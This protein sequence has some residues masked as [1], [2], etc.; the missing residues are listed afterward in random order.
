MEEKIRKMKLQN[1]DERN[2][3]RTTRL[4]PNQHQ[5]LDRIQK[6]KKAE[7]KRAKK[8]NYKKKPMITMPEG[9]KLTESQDA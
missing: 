3:K 6:V 2:G 5:K 4:K 8:R 9:E 7:C 1:L